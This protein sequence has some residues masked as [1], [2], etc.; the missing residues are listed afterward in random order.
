VTQGWTALLL[1][2][3]RPGPDPLAEAFGTRWKALV[4]VAGET[5]L[6][7]VANTLLASPSIA[8]VIVLA[9]QPDE[10]FVGDCAWLADE[11][12]VG[13][14]VSGSGIAG[15][16]AALAGAAPAPW[17]V[18]ATTADHPLLTPAMVETIVA[19]IGDADVAVGVVARSVLLSAYPDNRRTWLAFA[20][21]GWTGANLFAFRTPAALK[22]LAAW[23]AVEQ[24]RKKALKLVW[25]FGAWLAI[26]AVTRTITLAG[27]MK[28][29]GRRL[30]FDARP[31]ALPFAEA[32]ID[33]DKPSDH[34][35]AEAILSG[36]D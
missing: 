21:D 8:Q 33:V 14:A 13:T 16:I 25:H 15:S 20:D 10:L 4:P 27:A 9:Q 17:P 28:R 29:A 36:N 22:A 26:R 34:A 6:S 19:G 23:S 30:G 11:P 7:R 24:D 18:L 2:G 1:A 32:G 5:M 31:V 12:R 35:L 3:Q